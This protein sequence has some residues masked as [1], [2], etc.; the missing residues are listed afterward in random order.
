MTFRNPPGNVEKQ[1]GSSVVLEL[2][3]DRL[4]RPVWGLHAV[5]ARARGRL[6]RHV[7]LMT[8]C[9]ISSHEYIVN[10]GDLI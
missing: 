5:R 2:D 8:H 1:L 4:G 3:L 10:L 9:V 7:S 6:V